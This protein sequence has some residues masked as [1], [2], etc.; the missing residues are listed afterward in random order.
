MLTTEVS[1]RRNLNC[2]RTH[3]LIRFLIPGC[4]PDTSSRAQEGPEHMNHDQISKPNPEQTL[5]HFFSTT[6][7]GH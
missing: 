7:D 1:H 6:L 3:S 5:T 4:F 2:D